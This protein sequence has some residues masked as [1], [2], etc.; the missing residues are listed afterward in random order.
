MKLESHQSAEIKSVWKLVRTDSYLDI[1]GDIVAA[2]EESGECSL[3]VAGKTK[4]WTLGPGGFRIV[5]RRR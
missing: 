4:D 3:C 1:P 2:D 5:S